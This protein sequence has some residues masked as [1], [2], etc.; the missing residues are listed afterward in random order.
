MGERERVEEYRRRLVAARE[1]LRAVPQ[2]GPG[3]PGPAD[4]ETG[5]QWDR[6]NV[7]G[8]VAEMLPYWTAQGRTVLAGAD[9][10]GRDEPGSWARRE[11]IDGGAG[12]ADLPAA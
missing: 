1:Q 2:I 9:S 11:G 10:F 12:H 6:A 8:H 3:S 5:E 7:L 4:P